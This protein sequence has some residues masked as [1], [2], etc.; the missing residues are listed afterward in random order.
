MD[1]ALRGAS[2]VV[3]AA[4]AT[5]KQ[6]SDSVD[7]RGVETTANA[8]LA[9]GTVR[10]FLLI[11]SALV[12]Q[13]GQFSPLRCL[14]NTCVKSGIMDAKLL[15]EQA[16]RRSG[17]PYT[18]VRPGGLQDGPGGCPLLVLQG[19][20]R[21]SG[22][23]DRQDVA[24]VVLLVLQQPPRGVSFEVLRGGPLRTD[25]DVTGALSGLVQDQE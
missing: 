4:A 15:G 9:A 21:K 14:I 16:L 10:H 11:S 24:R 6:P 1:R 19:D 5:G 20:K 25:Q 12:T 17:V 7:H 23:I 18:I 13:K 2:A 3:F 22:E 8:A